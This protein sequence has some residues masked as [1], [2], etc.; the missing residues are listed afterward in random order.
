[1]DPHS[2][3]IPTRSFVTKPLPNPSTSL[4]TVFLSLYAPTRAAIFEVHVQALSCLKV[5]VYRGPLPET[6]LPSFFTWPTV[7]YPLELSLRKSDSRGKSTQKRGEQLGHQ[8]WL[9]P[10]RLCEQGVRRCSRACVSTCKIKGMDQMPAASPSSS[11][12]FFYCSTNRTLSPSLSP[13][14]FSM[15]SL[16]PF[17]H[18]S[19]CSISLLSPLGVS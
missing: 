11:H 3:P 1:M 13:F 16:K 18:P 17:F 9:C 2:L 19:L 12:P 5:F 8:F 7:C 14:L 4:F 15:T 10:L 6:S